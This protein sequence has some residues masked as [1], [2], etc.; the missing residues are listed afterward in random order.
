VIQDHI[1]FKLWYEGTENPLPEIW[2]APQVEIQSLA[3]ID[4]CD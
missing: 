1:Q 2:H 4:S 3:S